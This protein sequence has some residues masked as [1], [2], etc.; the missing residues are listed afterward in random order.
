LGYLN[1]IFISYKYI[2]FKFSQADDRIV[3]DFMEQAN[4]IR[5]K[6]V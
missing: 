1:M 6:A 2:Y 5:Q 3:Y 4:R